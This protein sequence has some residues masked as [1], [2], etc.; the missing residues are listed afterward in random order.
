MDTANHTENEI[1]TSQPSD[2]LA[3]ENRH[4]TCEMLDTWLILP[5][6]ICLS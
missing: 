3:G 1:W 5:V 6:V 4:F 2:G